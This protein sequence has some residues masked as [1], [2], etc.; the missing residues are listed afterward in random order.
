[1]K[2]RLRRRRWETRMDRELRF[3]VESQISDYIRQGM[4][5]R[6]AEQ[7]ARREFGPLEL[8]KEECHDT[9]PV[10]WLDHVRR[11]FQLAARSLR[12]SPGFAIAAIITLALGIGANTAIFGA[13]Y[14]VLL[15]RFRSLIRNK[16]TPSKFG[17]P[18]GAVA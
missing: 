13:I 11:D 4:G 16:S 12:K 14:A 5:R 9:E 15:K 6:E 7:R 10:Q 2:W 8:A 1:M 17:Y 3:H 18:G